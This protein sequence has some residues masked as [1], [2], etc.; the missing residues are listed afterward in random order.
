[1]AV[2]GAGG[3]HRAL[4]LAL[5]PVVHRPI[6]GRR[7]AVH[8]PV[9]VGRRLRVGSGRRLLGTGRVLVGA[10]GRPDHEEQSEQRAR[11]TERSQGR[12]HLRFNFG[13]LRSGR[14]FRG[15]RWGE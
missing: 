3:V 5:R 9:L 15:H 1:M 14:K 13:H 6:H 8:H 4:V 7:T 10:A 2:G 11:A 12:D